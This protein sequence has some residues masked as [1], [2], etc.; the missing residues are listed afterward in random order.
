MEEGVEV[1]YSTPGNVLIGAFGGGG[2]MG[3]IKD[4]RQEKREEDEVGVVEGYEVNWGEV[5][6]EGIEMIGQPA[7]K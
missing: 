4:E 3:G 5:G 6:A 2:R 1:G 7:G